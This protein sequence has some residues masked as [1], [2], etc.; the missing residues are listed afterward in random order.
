MV[1]LLWLCIVYKHLITPFKTLILYFLSTQVCPQNHRLLFEVFDENRLVRLACIFYF[2][3]EQ[4]GA[5]L[6]RWK[7]RLKNQSF[8]DLLSHLLYTLLTFWKYP[9]F[10]GCMTCIWPHGIISLLLVFLNLHICK[11]TSLWTTWHMKRLQV[12]EFKRC[13]S[14]EV[15][16]FMLGHIFKERGSV[17]PVLS[18]SFI[19][20]L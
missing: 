15:L 4:K 19:A 10:T 17:Q 20:L 9:D 3:R 7:S 8:Y 2:G 18:V 13:S 11:I 12:K 14:S 1:Q 5:R 16:D 6:N